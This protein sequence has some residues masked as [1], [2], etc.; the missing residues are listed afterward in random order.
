MEYKEKNKETMMK[1]TSVLPILCLDWMFAL[2]TYC[3]FF[4]IIFCSRTFA[5]YK[6]LIY[7]PDK[8]KSMWI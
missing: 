2:I 3:I 5:L 8:L 7:M 1:S 6:Y 4:L